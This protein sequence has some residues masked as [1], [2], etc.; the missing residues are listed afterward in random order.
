MQEFPVT[1]QGLQEIASILLVG[2]A[3]FAVLAFVIR[4]RGGS[5]R[6]HLQ[7]IGALAV[8]TTLVYVAAFTV[9]P[10]IP[11]PPVPFTARFASNPVADA[12][13]SIDAGRRVYQA[14]C[15]ICHGPR[16]KGDGPAAFT[17]NPR[18]FD[19][20][21]HVPRHPTGEVYHWISE[22]VAGTGMPAWKDKLTPEERW[23]IIRYIDALA[24]G[25]VAQ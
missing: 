25:R 15:A 13:A 23:Q 3:V 8:L 14:S 24:A 1:R 17:L 20:Q 11:T 10:N 19:L 18:P 2:I 4:Q 21:V 9:A 5:P 7:S 12:D 22:G 16:A 6:R